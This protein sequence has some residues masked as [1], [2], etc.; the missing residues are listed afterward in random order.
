VPQII[1]A[2]MEQP[3]KPDK[4]NIKKSTIYL[5]LQKCIYYEVKE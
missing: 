4:N 5:Y 1:L 2:Q 3:R